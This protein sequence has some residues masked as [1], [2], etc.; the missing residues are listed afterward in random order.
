MRKI[1]LSAALGFLSISAFS[2]YA[3]SDYKRS[4]APAAG[5]PN[6]DYSSLSDT[7]D[8]VHTHL[9]FDL[10]ALPTNLWYATATMQVI[11][12]QPTQRFRFQ[13]DGFTLD[14]ASVNGTSVSVLQPSA[15]PFN[16]LDNMPTWNVGDTA[17]VVIHYSGT[18]MA[19]F[20]GWG[21]WHNSNPYFFN[22]GVG[23]G[24]NPHSYG[25]S[26]FPAFDNF[27]EHSTY[28][29]HIVTSNGR[30]AYAN[31]LRTSFSIDPNTMNITQDW[32][33]TDPMPAYLPSVAIS[34]YAELTD[35]IQKTDGTYIPSMI[36]ARPGD[37]V[38]AKASFA[39][40]DGIFNSF[41]NWFGPYVWDKVGYALTTTG[42]MEH[43]TSIH[44]PVSIADGT[45]QREDIIAHELAHHW[46]GDLITCER[47]EDMWINEGMAEFSSHLYAEDV[48]SRERYMRDVRGNQLYVLN[49]AHIDDDGYIALNGVDHS[50]T[51]GSHVY[52][53]GAWIG[54]NLRG[55]LGDSLYSYTVSTLFQQH[56]FENF[57]TQTF[58]NTLSSISGVNM[59]DFFDDWVTVPGQ[60]AVTI[61]SMKVTPNAA[62]YTATVGISQY[63]G[64]RNT[65]LK[66][67]P[68][69]LRIYGIDGEMLE[70][71]VLVTSPTQTE[72]ITQIP[73]IP[74]YATIN[75]GEAYLAG[76]TFN[77]VRGAGFNI[78][79]MDAAKGRLTV[80]Q[81]TDTHD[82]YIAQHWAGPESV[83]TDVKFA[84]G[85][86]WSIRG[87]WGGDFDGSF[88]FFYDG[89]NQNGALDADLLQNT[90]DSL[91]L[92]YRRDAGEAWTLYPDYTLNKMGSS[93]D[94]FGQITITVLQAGDYVLA[95]APEDIG[96]GENTPH[97]NRLKVY[98]N[99][100]DGEIKIELLA[101]DE[102]SSPLQ[103][104]DS[105]GKLV[106]NE[107]WDLQPG[108]N[109]TRIRIELASGSYVLK[110]KAGEQ[111]IL[112]TR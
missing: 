98:P 31:G 13:L 51:Y 47:A 56:A 72:V 26:M 85:R 87:T 86:Y 68:M 93:T 41:E 104:F 28:S 71:D 49:Y 45:F 35:S 81:S 1:L 84:T 102:Q 78:Y 90:E 23:F 111:N 39:H 54:H 95:N 110:T 52:Q 4:A 77:H 8:I 59:A 57:N 112:I 20:T 43:A 14:S 29:F 91:V 80:T 88:R 46:W 42:A 11:K 44:L 97:Q 96:M 108:W 63:R 19:D 6:L 106:Y 5:T 73:F 33:C 74:A 109:E 15:Y 105:A 58:E 50:T 89:R 69:K 103:L 65:Y 82:V 34:N 62:T 61:D 21:G 79:D 83:A 55:Y 24:V 48:Y 67:A 36:M 7:F 16:M 40:L 18:A 101:S 53:K 30:M 9:D 37:T 38:N 10:T 27:V 76:S 70:T 32:V 3:C 66:S 12:K 25:R 22:L 75:E 100:S 2:Q 94:Q 64:H 107:K 60:V 92:L 17:D 99:P